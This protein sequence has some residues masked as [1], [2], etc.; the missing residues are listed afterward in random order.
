MSQ[1]ALFDFV[2]F[3][4]NQEN[5]ISY[6]SR[7][8]QKQY[9][10]RLKG[11]NNFDEM[12]TE[13]GRNFLP[14]TEFSATI[15]YDL[16]SGLVDSDLFKAMNC[17]YIIV[18]LDYPNAWSRYFPYLFYFIT[19]VRSINIRTVE[20]T[21][22]LDI[23]NT[24]PRGI[25]WSLPPLLAVDRAHFKRYTLDNNTLVYNNNKYALNVE[26]S[27]L[28]TQVTRVKE[29]GNNYEYG[30]II[31]TWTYV[32]LKTNEGSIAN[33]ALVDD[34][35]HT[36][37]KTDFLTTIY[38]NN[39]SG[40]NYNSPFIILYYLSNG[41]NSFKKGD[42]T[43]TYSG[44]LINANVQKNLSASIVNIFT[45]HLE[46]KQIFDCSY[47]L[48]TAI[49]LQPSVTYKSPNNAWDTLHYS[50]ASILTVY[51]GQVTGR[52]WFK[53]LQYNGMD[54][55][56]PTD[57]NKDAKYIFDPAIYAYEY[58]VINYQS[59]EIRYN[60][61][62]LGIGT[63]SVSE[64]YTMTDNG[65]CESF[66]ISGEYYPQEGREGERCNVSSKID[67]PSIS[68]PYNNWLANNKNYGVTSY[69]VPSLTG[70]TSALASFVAAGAAFMANSNPVG[71]A[72]TGVLALVSTL[73]TIMKNDS[74]IDD[75]KNRP[76]E[77]RGSSYDLGN[78]L[79]KYDTLFPYL[80]DETLLPNVKQT[81]LTQLYLFGYRCGESIS[82]SQLFS[83]YQ[84][85]YV[86]LAEPI[87]D[88]ITLIGTDYY[89]SSSIM[90]RISDDYNRGITEWK[91]KNII[92]VERPFVYPS[93]YNES[94]GWSL[95]ENWEED[96]YETLSN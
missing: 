75:I 7:N 88:K 28:P 44:E 55:N 59:N 70:G 45:T 17:Q 63:P 8:E 11:V 56:I 21:L 20:Y 36:Q 79:V 6:A 67:L 69:L 81:L 14:L 57:V 10:E 3:K 40:V 25:A 54:I 96:I 66:S 85:N 90:Q 91:Y 29:L 41:N 92:T 12:F 78:L 83:R 86:K 24:Y 37:P 46:P 62:R 48:N 65:V 9:F 80:K 15:R 74:A 58:F 95:A 18:K 1:I 2:P 4:V 52:V 49:G 89:M 93:V 42:D 72:V 82:Q 87:N 76:D 19:A 77:V 35:G 30:T 34:N 27:S 43:I 38:A 50:N 31:P 32:V 61:L 5:I 51:T 39:F 94:E 47:T 64:R 22:E 33:L 71:W 13:E 26:G 68:D 73:G 60:K 53:L 16:N 84:F 23:Y